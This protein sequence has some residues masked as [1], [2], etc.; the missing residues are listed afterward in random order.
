MKKFYDSTIDASKTPLIIDCGSNI[1]A[2][3]NYFY[4][5]YKKSKLVGIEG[6]IENYNTSNKNIISK[7]ITIYNKVVSSDNCNYQIKDQSIKDG[8]SKSFIKSDN[9]IVKS[10]LLNDIIKKFSKENYIPFLI[11]IDLEGAEKDLFKKN[12]EWFR[13][14]P[15]IMIEIHDWLEPSKNISS[16]FLKELNLLNNKDL[17]INNENLIVINYDTLK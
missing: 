3:L 15:V 11:K 4:L 6:D 16:G 10:I 2:S 1:G 12:I 9:G 14:F 7:K 13:L 8:R 5:M 17:L